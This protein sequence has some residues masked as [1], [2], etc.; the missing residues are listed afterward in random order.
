MYEVLFFILALMF[1]PF[2]VYC[3]TLG[4]RHGRIVSN[5]GVPTVPNPVS[6]VKEAVERAQEEKEYKEEAENWNEMAT[7]SAEKMMKALEE[8]RNERAAKGLM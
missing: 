6:A 5:G 8:K 2:C 7:F 1:F 3:Y 4:A